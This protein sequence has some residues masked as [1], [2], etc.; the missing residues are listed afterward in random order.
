MADALGNGN[1]TAARL[2]PGTV[3]ADRYRI[4]SV[5]GAGTFGVVWRARHVHLE[6]ECAVKLFDPPLGA[7]PQ[8]A[9]ARFLQE[10]RVMA[11]LKCPY[12][13]QVF[14][15]G[16]HEQMPFLVLELLLGS[17][18]AARLQARR[19]QGGALSAA[20]TV[21]IIR[22]VAE[23]LSVAHP[24]GVVHRDL[25]P[26]NI[27]LVQEGEG[28]TA[29]VLD[30]GIAKWSA[31]GVP[32][33]TTTRTVMGTPHYM[34]PEQFEGAQQV[35]HR[36]D[37]WSLAVIAF[38]CM[39]GQLPFPGDT[40]IDVAFQVC[41]QGPLVASQ[42][43]SVPPGFDAWFARA[44]ALGREFR[45][46][47]ALELVE[48]LEQVCW[49]PFP[50]RLPRAEAAGERPW[51]EFKASLSAQ[52]QARWRAAGAT[53]ESVLRT[54]NPEQRRRQRRVAGVFG[55]AAL[56]AGALTWLSQGTL[57]TS[58]G[59]TPGKAPMQDRAAFLQPADT[60]LRVLGA[61]LELLVDGKAFGPLPQELRDLSPSAHRIQV[62][63]GPR[64][65]PFDQLVV[66]EPNRV[67]SIGPVR[68]KV[69]RGL[70]TIRA[71]WGA[72]GAEVVH[73]IGDSRRV[74]ASLPVQLE[75][76]AWL[77]N[78]LRAKREGFLP[79]EQAIVFED[80]QAEKDFEVELAIAASAAGVPESG[81][82]ALREPVALAPTSTP[83][84]R[85]P[86]TP[87]K[88]TRKTQ[89]AKPSTTPSPASASKLDC[90]QPFW[91]D[92]KGVRRLKMQ[93]L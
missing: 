37:L 12:V 65:A 67:L 15:Y 46:S 17:S 60:G 21:R 51:V 41:K 56:V 20:D 11:R 1:R 83:A 75:I 25:K 59:P 64:Y 45:F 30:F 52:M 91:I 92:E 63:G 48:A 9:S 5:L 8:E 80:G 34:S 54:D 68:L 19:E 85:K 93:C 50:S 47:S 38:E 61:G 57:P 10:A 35:D 33:M 31:D 90:R 3:L 70:A 6:T 40:F 66:I 24:A 7:D 55:S 69:R 82:P 42:L 53:F 44:T 14:D 43:A 16:V 81:A 84:P 77:P 23:A 88:R 18:L 49:A 87:K 22:H 62:I 71:G 2:R 86:A 36:A 4:E 29:K 78:V 27:F 79:F 89:P 74:L 32:R 73:Q 76:D 72:A 39:T 13:A 28:T 58:L 26:E